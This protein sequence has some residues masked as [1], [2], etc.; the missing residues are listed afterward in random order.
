MDSGSPEFDAGYDAGNETDAGTDAG[1]DAG[2][3]SGQDGGADGG[4]PGITIDGVL[5]PSEWTGAVTVANSVATTWAGNELTRLLVMVR[6]DRLYLA[7]EGFVETTNAIVVYVDND[8]GNPTGVT[9]LTEVTDATGALDSALSIPGSAP[10]TTPATFRA[11]FAWGT[12]NM[13]RSAVG[14]DEFMGWRDLANPAD[15]AWIDST[16][17]PTACSANTCETYIPLPLLGGVAP[18]E[19]ALFARINNGSG[20]MSP[21]QALPTDDPSTPRAISSLLT[22]SE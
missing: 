4:S 14:L 15:L 13:G 6:E 12:R 9:T 16:N 8:L 19:I 3:D 11:D 10:Y 17:A 18:R 2:A 1:R 22:V 20:D 7:I 5:A 21:N